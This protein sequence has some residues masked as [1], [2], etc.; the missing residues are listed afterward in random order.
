MPAVDLNFVEQA[1][2]LIGRKP[3]D[4]IPILQA[5]QDHH[6][7]L[8][9]EALA[10]LSE[11]TEIHPSAISGVSTF[12]DMFRLKPANIFSASATAQPATSP[13]PGGSRTLCGGTCASR[14]A[15]TPM[16]PNN[17]PSNQSPASAVARWP[18]SSK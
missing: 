2:A 4:L 15:P 8:P 17:S 6:G 12:Y 14:Q 7:C 9:K 3:A 10:R 5:L 18:L 1:V 16:T 13:G 11:L